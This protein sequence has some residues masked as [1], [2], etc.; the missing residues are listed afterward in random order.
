MANATS[1]SSLYVGDLE[2]EVSE[3]VLFDVFREIGPVLSIRVCRDA[4]SKVSLGYAYV[5][6]Q[7]PLDAERA[8]ET[9]NHTSIKGRMARIMWCRRDPSLRKSGAGNIFIKNLD[10]AIDN[11]ALH[12]TFQSFGQIL[13]CKVVADED[14][15]SMGYGFVHYADE[16]DAD[17]AVSEVNG[18]LMNGKQVYVGRFERKERKLQSLQENFTNLYVKHFDPTVPEDDLKKFFENFGEIES[19]NC[20]INQ[21]AEN[22][23]VIY[24][25]YKNHEDAAKAIQEAND[26]APEGII[27]EGK[28]LVVTRHQKKQE[29][30]FVKK[31]NQKERQQE[32]LKF[33]N[34]YVKNLDD[35]V[36]SETLRDAFSEFGT[37]MSCKVMTHPE[38]NISKG[39]GF[40]SF[41]DSGAAKQA[42]E[43]M[44]GRMLSG[45]PLFVTLAQKKDARKA[46][47]ETLYRGRGSVNPAFGG[48]GMMNPAMNQMPFM[49]NPMNF[50]FH[51]GPPGG[52]NNY[53]GGMQRGGQGMQRGPMTAQPNLM[54]QQRPQQAPFAFGAPSMSQNMRQPAP[55]G[56]GGPNRLGM[57]VRPMGGAPTGM[58]SSAPMDTVDPAKLAT[59]TQEGQKNHLGEKLFAKIQATEPQHAAKIT[60]MLLEMDNAEILNLLDSPDLLT[61]KVREA[62]SVLKRHGQ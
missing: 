41:K 55:V 54:R 17:K 27:L 33:T 9:L 20:Q 56:I 18:M 44:N 62:M 4:N 24:V 52:F 51:Q 37:M 23:G 53:P 14:G 19:F 36:T 40:V 30:E 8:I 1:S 45:K 35:S 25:N 2:K 57:G 7:N 60:G 15:K 50:G 32:L 34:L 11:K 58:P 47:L 6:F 16:K 21:G 10:S 42:T 31:A 61:Q 43:S 12:A 49:N 29:R 3:A 48:G 28:K 39:F 59:M 46:Q 26:T 5:N 22:S 38:T 13:S